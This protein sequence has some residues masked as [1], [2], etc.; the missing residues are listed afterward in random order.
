M[1]IS[2][3]FYLRELLLIF[4]AKSSQVAVRGFASTHSSN[5]HQAKR[6]MGLQEGF[7]SVEAEN[8]WLHRWL[9]ELQVWMILNLL[10][11]R[12]L[13]ICEHCCSALP[14]LLAPFSY[15]MTSQSRRLIQEQDSASPNVKN[16]CNEVFPLSRHEERYIREEDF[17]HH[18]WYF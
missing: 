15:D 18:V 6:S 2:F 17:V 9:M 1:P 8:G 3:L 4:T 12:L 16:S 14:S 13:H 7:I 10:K 5:I 11:V